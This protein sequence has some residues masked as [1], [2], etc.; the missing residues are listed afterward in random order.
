MPHQGGHDRVS[1]LYGPAHF[2]HWVGHSLHRSNKKCATE[3]AL[4]LLGGSVVVVLC[5]SG[6]IIKEVALGI[7]LH[8]VTGEGRVSD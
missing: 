4:S 7:G 1:S 6:F 3:V 5:R 2:V 8:S